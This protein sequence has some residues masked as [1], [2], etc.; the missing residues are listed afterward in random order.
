[1]VGVFR[2]AHTL[3]SPAAGELEC[4]LAKIQSSG[5][6]VDIVWQNT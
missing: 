6:Q 4:C 3:G 5:D 1:M 2:F